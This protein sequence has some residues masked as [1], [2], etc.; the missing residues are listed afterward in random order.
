MPYEEN[1]ETITRGE[2]IKRTNN[3]GFNEIESESSARRAK[4]TIPCQAE[5]SGEDVRT[6][7]E[8]AAKTDNQERKDQFLRTVERLLKPLGKKETCHR[9]RKE[10]RTGMEKVRCRRDEM[11]KNRYVLQKNLSRGGLFRYHIEKDHLKS[12]RFCLGE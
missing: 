9:R 6:R 11:A 4:S 10:K 5:G 8:D 3:S 1:R 7:A 12:L 2:R